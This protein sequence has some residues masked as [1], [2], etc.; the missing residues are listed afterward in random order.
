MSIIN[1][2]A[3]PPGIGKSTKGFDYVDEE[4]DILNEDEMRFR[5]KARGFA[6]YNEY[7]V[8]RVRDI[9]KGKLIR[10]KDF[11][12]ELNLGYPHQY[13]YALAAKNSVMKISFM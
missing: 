6:D 9:I 13:E 11:A 1:I 3:G 12:L 8:Y 10:N 4:L 2:I 5:Y 7:S